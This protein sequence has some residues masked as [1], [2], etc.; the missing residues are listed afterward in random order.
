MESP[1]NFY[2][3][4][5]ALPK[6]EYQKMLITLKLW[7]NRQRLCAA[8]RREEAAR[9]RVATER[10]RIAKLEDLIEELEVDVMSAAVYRGDI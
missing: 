10:Q 2:R 9:L 5:V 3:K 6:P 8:L 7:I 1:G 4:N